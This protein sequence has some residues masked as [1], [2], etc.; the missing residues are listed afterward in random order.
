MGED[1]L[2]VPAL[3]RSGVSDRFDLLAFLKD[4]K[5]DPSHGSILSLS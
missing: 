5:N 2:E 3:S 1:W 4:E